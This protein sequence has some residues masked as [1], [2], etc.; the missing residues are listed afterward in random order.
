[1][2]LRIIFNAQHRLNPITNQPRSMIIFLVVKKREY[3]VTTVT[4]LTYL[5]EFFLQKDSDKL[6][7][8]LLLFYTSTSQRDL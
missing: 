5:N 2:I 7:F 4:V 3:K 6:Y 1:M 8:M